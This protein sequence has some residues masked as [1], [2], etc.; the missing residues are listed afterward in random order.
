M[1]KGTGRQLLSVGSRLL[2]PIFRDIQ[3]I[4][5]IL[6]WGGLLDFYTNHFVGRATNYLREYGKVDMDH[7]FYGVGPQKYTSLIYPT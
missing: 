3:G 1:G 5:V 6:F 4:S 2:R 7:V